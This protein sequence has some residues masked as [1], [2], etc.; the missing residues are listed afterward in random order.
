[1]SGKRSHKSTYLTTTIAQTR[2]KGGN[3]LK[4]ERRKGQKIREAGEKGG[5][6]DGNVKFNCLFLYPP[7]SKEYSSNAPRAN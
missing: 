6:K 5:K 3:K 2:E 4:G 1:M 7:Q